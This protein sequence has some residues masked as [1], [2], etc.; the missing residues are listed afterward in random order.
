MCARSVTSKLVT[1][2]MR[3][4]LS[5]EHKQRLLD[6]TWDKLFNQLVAH[7]VT[8]MVDYRTFVT[9]SLKEIEVSDI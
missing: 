5:I 4:A 6:G 3:E 2:A 1:G 8:H 9:K 7:Y